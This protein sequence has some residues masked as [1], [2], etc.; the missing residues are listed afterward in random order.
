MAL[1]KINGNGKDA[2]TKKKSDIKVVEVKGKLVQKFNAA[3]AALSRAESEIKE[4]E[5]WIKR[6]GASHV[7]ELNVSARNGDTKSVKLVDE[8]GEGVR[9]TLSAAYPVLSEENAETLFERALNVDVNDYV[10]Q[11]RKAKFDSSAFIKD[12]AF[13]EKAYNAFFKACGDVAK[14]LGIENPLSTEVIIVVKPDFD[15]KRYTDFDI[16]QQAMIYEVVPNKTSI[17]PI[18]TSGE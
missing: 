12:D 13:N 2:A 6:E 15:Q 8:S 1:K 7:F 9:V 10:L 14:S 17:T 4:I 3:K 11:T 18:V 16:A 5:P